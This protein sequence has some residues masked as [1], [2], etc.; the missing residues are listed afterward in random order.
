MSVHAVLHSADFKPT[1]LPFTCVSLN[2]PASRKKQAL[3]QLLFVH[4]SIHNI[5]D[6]VR[7]QGGHCE[8]FR[9][10]PGGQESS[11]GQPQQS[12]QGGRLL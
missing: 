5:Y 4:V 3:P 10:G 11:A 9:G 7:Q 2:L 6:E 1:R 12:Q 8:D